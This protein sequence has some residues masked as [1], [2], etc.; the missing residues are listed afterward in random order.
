MTSVIETVGAFAGLVALVGLLVLAFLVI[1]QAR[2]LRRLREWAG[3]AP[4][5]DA[6]LREVSEVVA[7]ERAAEIQAVTEREER[8]LIRTGD[9]SPTFWERL[10]R[11]GQVMLVLAAVILVG[12]AAAWYLTGQDGGGS[13]GGTG[14]EGG[15]KAAKSTKPSKVTVAVFNGTGGAEA[16]L[17][18]EY[19]GFLEEKGFRLGATA[20]APETFD[21]TIVYYE[22]GSKAG[23]EL[24]AE[25]IDAESVELVPSEISQLA[26]SADVIAV[27][28][29][30]HSDLPASGA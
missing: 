14:G 5:R 16:G 23:A 1:S 24:V 30:N 6:E 22:N 7:E 17:A 11:S 28:G 19:S 21:E 13:G 29:L 18:A 4:E 27:I 15:G 10:G 3:G 9:L 8:R 25:E 26:P 12:A 2:D 20:D